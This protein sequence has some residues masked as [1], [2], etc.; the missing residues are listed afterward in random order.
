LLLY[1]DKLVHVSSWVGEWGLRGGIVAAVGEVIAEGQAPRKA[2]A[3]GR[4]V[5]EIPL[6]SIARVE[7]LKATGIA[8]LFGGRHLAGIA[9]L[10]GG[11]HLVVTTSGAIAYRFSVTPDYWVADIAHALRWLGYQVL[12][13]PQG[14]EVVWVPVA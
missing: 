4:G 8:G 5:T 14:I 10:F 7:N 6:H 11:R 1:P 13:T 2:A 3:G 12:P 9:G